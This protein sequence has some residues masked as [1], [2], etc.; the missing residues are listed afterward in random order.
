MRR[1]VIIGAAL[2]GQRAAQAAR[3]AG[4]DGEL[5]VVGEER[6]HPYTRPPLSKQLL[7]GEHTVERCD[8]PWAKLEVA[9][10]LGVPAARLDRD[11]KRV[12][13]ADGDEVPYDRLIVATGSRARQW[14]G[15]GGELDGVHTLRTLDDS[16]AL[17]TA[18]ERGGH[19]VVL[20]AG[21]IGCEVAAT[22]RGLGLEVTVVE[23]AEHPLLPLGA[24][25]GTHLAKIHRERGVDL[26]LQTGVASVI[27]NERVEAVELTDGT[28]VQTDVL[29]AALGA[30]PNTEWLAD[31]G[32]SLDPGVVCDVTLTAADDPD[33]LVAGD[34]ASHPHPLAGGRH[35]RIEHWTSASEHGQLAGANA[36][37]EPDERSPY[38]T[39]PYFW[40]D[41]YEVKVQSIGFT[42]DAEQLEVLE[43]STGRERFIAA[44]ARDGRLVAAVAVNAPRRLG[45]Y[46]SQ[47][48]DG[49]SI[50]SVRELI[51]ADESALGVA[52]GMVGA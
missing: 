37:L 11:S 40:S 19:L 10:R 36:L 23:I 5:V 15:G 14:P 51:R 46:R 52:D 21:F 25:V 28:V 12:V 13:L 24:E 39:A 7:A 18:L 45:W 32:L 38:T 41:Q 3:R 26:R 43:A 48:A 22:A 33:V 8:L 44:G 30:T 42:S 50:E 9:W 6:R 34:V 17:R 29:L 1:L 20:G 4:F 47:V 2:A 31:S 49:Q 35:V 27:G 16:L